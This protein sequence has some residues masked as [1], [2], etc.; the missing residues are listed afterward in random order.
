MKVWTRFRRLFGPEPHADV[1]HELSFHLEMRIGE[2]VGEGLSSDEARQV[3]LRRFGDYDASRN[4]CVEIDTRLRR[5][6]TAQDYLRELKQDAGYAL[7]MLRRTPGFTV[8]ALLTLGLGIGANSAIFSVVHG[9]V[10]QALPYRDGDRLYRVRTLYPDGT[11]Y[12]LS[13]PDFMSVRRDSRAFEQVEGYSAGAVTLLGAG[14]PR[15][16]QQA[17]VTDGLFSLLGLPMASGRSFVRDDH[18]AGRSNVAVLHHGFWQRQFGADPLVIGRTISLGGRPNTVIGVLAPGARL[19]IAA[20]VYAPIEYDQTFDAATATGRRSEFLAVLGRAKPG[21]GAAEIERD[22]RRLG[23]AL[24]TAFPQTNGALTFTAISL[25]E[26][27]VGDVRTPLLVLLG[28]VTFVLLVACANVANLL[29]ARASARQQEIAVRAALGANRSR[30][31][32]Q[33]LTESVVLGLAGGAIGLAIA[34]G[35]TRALVAAQPADIPRLDEIGVDGLVVLFTLA[36]ALVTSVLFGIAPALQITGR[37]LTHALREGARGGGATVSGH[38][39]RSVLVVVEMALAVV[40]LTGAGLLIHSFV[41]LTQVSPGFQADRA[42][43]FRLML[44][45]PAYAGGPQVRG[46]IV[47]LEDRLRALPGVTTVAATTVLPLGGRGALLD[48][49]VVGAPPPPANV[50]AEISVASVTPDYFTAIGAPLRR[51]RGFTTRDASDTPLV[52]LINDAAARMWFPGQDP[53]GKFVIVGGQRREIVG[54][55]ADVLQRDLSRPAAPQLFA[56]YTQRTARTLRVVVRTADDPIAH[57]PAIREAIR[58]VDPNLAI[59]SFTPFTQLIDD[60]VARPRF[61]MSLLALFAGVALALAAS[62]IF[63]VMSYAVTQRSRE[64]SIRMALGAPAAGVL[65]EIVG[66][67]AALAAAGVVLGTA[68]SLALGRVIQG[69]LFG[70]TVFDPLTLAAVASVLGATAV[71]ASFLPARRAAALDPGG[72]LRQG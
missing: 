15:E 26:L 35:G 36:S 49:A 61:Y 54:I 18:Q 3:A 4:A 43:T 60:S 71:A 5:R 64:I 14:E 58:S 39:V 21:F 66:R 47:E 28:A 11:P 20:D 37:T 51:G 7:R 46:R 72:A 27:I 56:P 12:S 2:L 70:V 45:G 17:G 42:L 50:N 68:A 25:R 44:Q 1:E 57:A 67:G 6:M 69:Q 40:L 63:G 30:L 22:L 9:V 16:V 52:A 33:L 38:R 65:R 53:L 10:L 48:F 31:F 34:F 23:T 32:R 8:V 62:G 55:V 19:P 24:Q 13:A 29:L 59:M 41:E